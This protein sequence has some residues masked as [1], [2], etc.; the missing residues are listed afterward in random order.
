MHGLSLRYPNG[1]HALR[2]IDLDARAGELSIV[3]GGNGCGKTTLLKCITRALAPDAGQVWLNGED[4]ATLNAEQ[5]RKAR[6]FLG[7]IGQHANLVGRRSVLA[8]VACGALARNQ[9]LWTSCGGGV[10]ASE[11]SA[12][13][14]CLGQVGLA[15][16]AAQRASTLSGGQAQRAAIARALLQRPLVLLADEPV[17]SLDPE[18]AHD[19]MRLLRSLAHEKDLAVVCV[20]HQVDLAFA[21]A[22]RV[23]GMREGRVA[24]DRAR[25]HLAMDEVQGL[26]V[27]RAA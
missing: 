1:T 11:L 17:A 5:L 18:A 23:I 3:L 10:P 26:Y 2:G 6:R 15:G 8:N 7:M 22:D 27:A 21:F 12:G 14:A 24:F 13:L 16:L 20:L 19:I 4:L 9:T 25:A